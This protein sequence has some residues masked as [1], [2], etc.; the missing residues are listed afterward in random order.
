MKILLALLALTLTQNTFASDMSRTEDYRH[1]YKELKDG[2]NQYIGGCST[3][4]DYEGSQFIVTKTIIEYFEPSYD[5]PQTDVAKRIHKIEKELVDATLLHLKYDSLADVDDLTV[6]K[7]VSKKFKKLDLFRLN[8]GV[9]GGNGMYLVF[10]R[11]VVNG[12]IVYELMSDVFDGDVEF[13]D[14]KIWLK[15]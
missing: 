9:G 10:N 2:S 1:A 4:Q 8:I 12:K 13:C 5:S 7:I 11:E 3:H 14:S 15:K 6:E